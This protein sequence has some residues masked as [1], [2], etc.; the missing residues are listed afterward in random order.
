MRPR[1]K[2]FDQSGAVT[3]ERWVFTGS[4]WEPRGYFHYVSAESEQSTTSTAYQ[5]ALT[6]TTDVI[7]AGDY[8]IMWQAA[9]RNTSLGFATLARVQVDGSDVIDEHYYS[10]KDT[11]T[12]QRMPIAGTRRVNFATDAA[13]TIDFD[14]HKESG[15]GT[16]YLYNTRLAIIDAHTVS[17]AG[18]A[19]PAHKPRLKSVDQSGATAD[20]RIAWN[21]SAWAP[22]GISSQ[23]ESTSR[24][25]TTSTSYQQK[26][27][28]TTP[29]LP[30]GRYLIW[31]HALMDRSSTSGDVGI[32]VQEN[33]TDTLQEWELE[34]P[35]NSSTQ[36]SMFAGFRRRNLSAGVYNYDID[37]RTVQS[38][39]TAGIQQAWV[40]VMQLEFF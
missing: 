15:S 16:S 25:T 32:R 3:D 2:S 29:S 8:V 23:S 36:R 4:I 22:I 13:H 21:G 10:M 20:Q 39:A 11:S 17:T 19:T 6:V 12:N 28:H 27:R 37:F 7:P 18:A 33:D 1:I 24:S 14:Y 40:T 31:W 34:L 5:T 9:T 26:H 35:H 30:Q 38:G